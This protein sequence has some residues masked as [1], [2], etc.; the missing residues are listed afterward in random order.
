MKKTLVL[1][2]CAA[3]IYSC[4]P[5]TKTTA[6]EAPKQE[7]KT[8]TSMQPAAET[9][10]P[11]DMVMAE[12]TTRTVCAGCHE[13]YPAES[14]TAAQWPGIVKSMQ[15]KAGFSDTE[16]AQILAYLTANAKK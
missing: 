14:H 6:T 16:K 4:S 3:L 12:K 7:S 8:T 9:A 13:Y 1:A 10:E 15:K 5:K 2:I 11:V